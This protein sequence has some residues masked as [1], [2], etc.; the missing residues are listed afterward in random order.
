M[1]QGVD[2]FKGVLRHDARARRALWR[3]P[4]LRHAAGRGRDDRHRHRHGP[5]RAAADPHA[6]SHG[7]H[8]AGDEPDRQ[9]R[10]QEPLHVRRQPSPCR[11]SFARS[12]AGAGGRG[13]STRRG[14]TRSSCTSP[15]CAS[16]RRPRRTTPRAAWCRPFATTTRSSSSSIA[17]CTSRRG[18]CRRS[19]TRC[20]SARPGSGGRRRR[21]AGR[22]VARGARLPAR[23][24]LLREKGIDAEVIDPVSLSPLDVDTIAESV[25]K[26]GRLLV[27]D[28]AWT[29]CGAAPRSSTQV[30]ERLQGSEAVRVPPSGLRAVVCPTTKK[31]EQRFYPNAA[32]IAAE[33]HRLVH[34]A[35]RRGS[36]QAWSI[37]RSSSSA[38]RFRT[39][40]P[41]R[42]RGNP[43]PV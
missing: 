42:R 24:R 39:N 4:L 10:R 12:S 41:V 29:M 13:R 11:S 16:S 36:R 28:S 1:G 21:H 23:R 34:G 20:R 38:A 2:D 15:A 43:M 35:R 40:P 25:S 8:A 30:G 26:T 33:A 18:T 27:A 14:C 32:T 7:F 22:H 9:H 5:R 37:R 17:C 6:H 19:S 31:L 3:R